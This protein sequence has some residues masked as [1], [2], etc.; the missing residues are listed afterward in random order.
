MP[1]S[2]GTIVVFQDQRDITGHSLSRNVSD[3]SN[4]AGD[5]LGGFN[6]GATTRTLSDSDD[7]SDAAPRGLSSQTCKTKAI[8]AA[9]GRPNR[10]SQHEAKAAMHKL[11]DGFLKK[12]K[13]LHD[14]AGQFRNIQRVHSF[15]GIETIELRFD[16]EFSQVKR[17]RS[18]FGGFSVAALFAAV[19][20]P[21]QTRVVSPPLLHP[22]S[23][24]RSSSS[25]ST[26]CSVV[27]RVSASLER[28]NASILECRICKIPSGESSSEGFA[29]EDQV[30]EVV[31]RCKATTHFA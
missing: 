12:D 7:S 21:A 27:Y 18:G 14:Q 25:S 23:P 22:P 3:N 9:Y 1:V 19:Q 28:K 5:M 26:S 15:G 10:V 16:A 30:G 6:R 24:S 2:V 20:T 17:K 4:H 11:I 31:F 29:P 8:S 13:T